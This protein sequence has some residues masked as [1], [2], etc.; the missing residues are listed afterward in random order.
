MGTAGGGITKVAGPDTA[1][2]PRVS[3]AKPSS[4]RAML[5]APNNT[6]HPSTTNP[7]RRNDSLPP[8][9]ENPNQATAITAMSVPTGPVS[10][11][12]VPLSLTNG[13]G[14]MAELEAAKRWGG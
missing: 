7:P 4:P 13:A 1:I 10:Q 3:P 6:K 12:S 14:G 8:S 2:G 11:L 5:G 9:S